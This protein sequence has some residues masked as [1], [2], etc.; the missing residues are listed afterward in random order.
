MIGCAPREQIGRMIEISG[1]T[2]S[3]IMVKPVR[4]MIQISGETPSIIMVKPVRRMI[5]ISGE[6]PSIIMRLNYLI[7]ASLKTTCL[8]ATGSYFRSSS[9]LVVV[10][11]FFFVT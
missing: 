11:A 3:I 7:F 10:R 2:P 9:L 8:R 4:R 6:T 5:Q 1:E